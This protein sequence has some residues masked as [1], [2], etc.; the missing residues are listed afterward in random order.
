MEFGIG[1]GLKNHNDEATK[2]SKKF[3]DMLS[4]LDRRVHADTSV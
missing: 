1:V 4:R 2:S 3:K